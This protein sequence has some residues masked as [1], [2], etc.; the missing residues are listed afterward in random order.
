MHDLGTQHLVDVYRPVDN[1]LGC[2]YIFFQTGSVESVVSYCCLCIVV[3]YNLCNV[4]DAAEI[5]FT[6]NFYLKDR[7]L[8]TPSTKMS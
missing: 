6:K 1:D 5:L 7:Q 8:T 4:C 3:F 2:M